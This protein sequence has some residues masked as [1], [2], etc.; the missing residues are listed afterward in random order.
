MKPFNYVTN[1]AVIAIV[2]AIIFTAIQRKT[3]GMETLWIGS[4]HGL[5]IG[6]PLILYSLFRRLYLDNLL[7]KTILLFVLF[8]NSGVYL[9]LILLSRAVAMMITSDSVFLLIPETDGNFI[10]TVLFVSVVVFFFNFLEQISFLTGKRQLLYLAIGKYRNARKENRLIMFLDLADS[11][12]IAEQIGDLQYLYLLDDFFSMLTK[13]LKR[14]QGEIYKYI[15]DE[16][17]ITWKQEDN[18]IGKPVYFFELFKNRIDKN[19]AF[20]IKKYG[21]CPKFR[22]GLHLG[23]MMIGE[24]GSV[25]KEI[26]LIGDTINTT[27][28][29]LDVGKKLDKGLVLSKPV[30]DFITTEVSDY[31]FKNLGLQNIKGKQQSMNLYSFVENASIQ[32]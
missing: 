6:L 9:V 13:P 10:N 32:R 3:L 2:I 22:A 20:F 11:T 5:I 12:K 28:R 31:S 25:K 16:V 21:V 4:I 1:R 17:I 18:K 19:K 27:S 15:G 26:A 29:I 7:R 8:F 23:S 14:T 24:L 30:H